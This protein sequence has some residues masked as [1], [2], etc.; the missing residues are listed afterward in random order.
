[1]EKISNLYQSIQ[2]NGGSFVS[3]NE[4]KNRSDLLIF[5]GI[6]ENELSEKFFKKFSGIKKKRKNQFSF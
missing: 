2:R 6:S 5:L 4:M 1:M 3:F